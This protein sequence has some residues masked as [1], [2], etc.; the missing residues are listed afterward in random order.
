MKGAKGTGLRK[1]IFIFSILALNILP[2][3]ISSLLAAELHP[4]CLPTPNPCTKYHFF[5]FKNKG[6]VK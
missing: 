2:V 6:R 1:F 4:K 3:K 5:E